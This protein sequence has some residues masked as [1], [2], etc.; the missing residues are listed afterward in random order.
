M[1]VLGSRQSEADIKA[2][3]K[4]KSAFSRDEGRRW[5]VVTVNIYV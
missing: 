1:S 4:M 3:W 5:R 2:D